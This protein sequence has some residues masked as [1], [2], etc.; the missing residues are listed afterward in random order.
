M[1][2]QYDD[3]VN[4]DTKVFQ[5][6]ED[7][8]KYC[9][10]MRN[11]GEDIN[12][13]IKE[14]ENR[15]VKYIG[16]KEVEELRKNAYE[17]ACYSKIDEAKELL[18]IGDPYGYFTLNVAE[19]YANM[20]NIAVPEEIEKLKPKA[21]KVFANYKFNEAKKT[22]E[23]DPRSS[24]VNLLLAKEH[25]IL[26]NIPL[27]DFFENVKIKAYTNYRNAMIKDAENVRNN[28]GYMFG[29]EGYPPVN[30]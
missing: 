17:V 26:A 5:D 24:I 25:A 19:A 7:L 23:T 10:D 12:P 22:L 14:K 13:C 16:A 1:G 30:I 29:D 15:G 8:E 21:H 28:F 27:P 3:R 4:G 2:K 6:Q 11:S 9:C 20:A 18:K